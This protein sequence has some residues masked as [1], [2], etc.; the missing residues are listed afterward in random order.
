V[1]VPVKQMLHVVGNVR[2]PIRQTIPIHIKQIV[3]ATLPDAIP[4][5]VAMDRGVPVALKATLDFD[6]KIIGT[7]PIQLGTL[8]FKKGSARLVKKQ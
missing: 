8:A 1:Q 2:V 3:G 7:V 4:V 5:S 6:V